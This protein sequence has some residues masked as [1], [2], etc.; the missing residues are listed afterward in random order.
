MK[1]KS[2]DYRSIGH[3]EFS[4]PL[5]NRVK[6]PSIWKCVISQIAHYISNLFRHQIAYPESGEVVFVTQSVNNERTL[7]PIA[8]RIN[9][10]SHKVIRISDF[11]VTYVYQYALKTWPDFLGF[12]HKNNTEDRLRI[13]KEFQYFVNAPGYRKVYLEY[14]RRN[15][16][17]RIIVVANDHTIPTRCLIET[18]RE[19]DIPVVY[20]QHASV[21]EAFPPLHFAYSFLDGRESYEKYLKVG[22]IKGKVVLLG[23]PRFDDVMP[24][25]LL[26]TNT[27]REAIGVGLSP[28][29]SLEKALRLCLHIKEK[30]N[31]EVIIRPHPRN[32]PT[33]DKA[34][35]TK[36]Q[37]EISDSTKETSYD[38]FTRISVLIANESGIHLDAAIFGI[39]AILFNFSNS[40]VFDWYGFIRQGLIQFADSFDHVVELI[41]LS[42]PAAIDKV[43]YYYAAFKTPYDGHIS[44]TIAAFLEAEVCKSEAIGFLNDHFV[45][46]EKNVFVIK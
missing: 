46:K 39:P 7:C 9:N 14:F 6:I 23:S 35:L 3:I 27:S 11:P 38:F 43:Q 44:E 40:K 30:T 8:E 1:R 17:I 34:L 18:A 12:Y 31:K 45:E 37:I 5:T 13:R 22:D 28:G 33:F 20:T 36:H 19:V 29:D 25:R 24:K 15:K 21:S 4:I 2:F 26:V 41:N 10:C 42:K 16:G 32:M